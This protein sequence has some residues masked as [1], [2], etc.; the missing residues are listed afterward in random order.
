MSERAPGFEDYIPSRLE[1]LAFILNS[2]AHY[3]DAPF[4]GTFERMYTPKEDGRTLVL[5]I[6]Y[7]KDTNKD[8][9]EEYIES[10]TNYVREYAAIYKWDSWLKIE[11]KHDPV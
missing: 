10:V 3:L 4:E 6:S 8:L 5:W 9:L 11:V 1:W 7:P 2:Y